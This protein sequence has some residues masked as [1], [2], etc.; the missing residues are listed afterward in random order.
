MPHALVRFR[1]IVATVALCGMVLA[2]CARGATATQRAPKVSSFTVMLPQGADEFAPFIV[3]VSVGSTV[4]W[5][6]QDTASHS[7]TTTPDHTSYLNPES[8][9]LTIPAGGTAKFVFTHPGVYDYY[10]TG[11]ATWNT[12]DHRVAANAGAPGFPLAMEGVI[13]VQGPIAGLSQ[14]VTDPIPGK[15]EYTSDF[16]AIPQGGTVAWYNDDT[17]DHDTRLVRGWG[18]PINPVPLDVGRENGTDNAPPNGETKVITFSTPGLY[19]YYCKIHAH[20]APQWR[21]AEAHADVSDFP[22]PMEAFI[23]VVPHS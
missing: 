22:I 15:D 4:I 23:L 3:P 20:I 16:L 19:Y 13:W 21:R 11:V 18:K 17:D 6:N 8:F 10:D 9:S 12:T 1:P 2:S 5:Q 14:T 7:F